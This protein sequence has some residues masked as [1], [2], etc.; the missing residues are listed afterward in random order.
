MS[1]QCWTTQLKGHTIH[2]D[3]ATVVVCTPTIR[4][5][6]GLAASREVERIL[7]WAE[8]HAPALSTTPGGGSRNCGDIRCGLLASSLNNKLDRYRNPLTETVEAL[9]A[10]WDQCNLLY[11]FPALKI[12]C[13]FLRIELEDTL[14]KY[15]QTCPDGYDAPNGPDY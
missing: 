12:P 7:S 4:E 5:E 9:V 10:Q 1:L 8:L 2:S 11:S 15:V 13:L 14:L 6:L 3:K